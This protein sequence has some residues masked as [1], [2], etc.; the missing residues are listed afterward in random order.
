M[1]AAWCFAACK[2]LIRC[3]SQLSCLITEGLRDLCKWG[4]SGARCL[5]LSSSTDQL[6]PTVSLS[7]DGACSEA[8]TFQ[9]PLHVMIPAME[10]DVQQLPRGLI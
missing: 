10:Q 9:G 8:L 3:C 2:M 1:I 5:L 4:E 6:Q 7:V